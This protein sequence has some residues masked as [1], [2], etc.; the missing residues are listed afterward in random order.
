MPINS[1]LTTRVPKPYTPSLLTFLD[2][3][4]VVVF[5]DFLHAIF[6]RI[7]SSEHPS[8]SSIFPLHLPHTHAFLLSAVVF[9]FVAS[10]W[11]HARA[12][13]HED[14]N[15]Y[16][17]YRRFFLDLL[18]AFLSY[19][20]LRLSIERN[21]DT[22]VFVALMLTGGVLWARVCLS[23]YPTG[24]DRAALRLIAYTHGCTVG[25]LVVV[26][27]ILTVVTY[28]G[29]DVL[30]PQWLLGS[31]LSVIILFLYIEDLLR[32]AFLPAGHWVG[33]SAP[34]FPRARQLQLLRFLRRK[35]RSLES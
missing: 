22:A 15:P 33:P 2:F 32:V 4:Y 24:P 16:R 12:L 10:D 7:Y 27:G 13:T 21:V 31:F 9:W 5:G 8:V 28:S 11:L 14:R 25:A 26:W 29:S 18:I 19:F 20:A 30:Q 17:S 6:D 34:F 23:D 35:F 1:L 3:V